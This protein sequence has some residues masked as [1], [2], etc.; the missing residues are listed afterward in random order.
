MYKQKS[1][2]GNKKKGKSR[3][4][5][6]PMPGFGLPMCTMKYAQALANPFSPHAYGACIP[7]GNFRP[8][9]K[10]HCRHFTSV[11]I[12]SGGF[13]YFMYSPCLANNSTCLF[14]TSSA[15]TGTAST[16]GN[17]SSVGV[18][19]GTMSTLP[20][21][22]TQLIESDSGGVRSEVQGRIVS[23]GIKWRYTG[24]E[25]NRG[26]TI[27]AYSDPLHETVEG[28][29]Y[30]QL[31][32]FAEAAMTAP[33]ANHQADYLTVFGCNFRELNYP[34]TTIDSSVTA[35][36]LSCIY[37]YSD[38]NRTVT[39][40]NTGAPIAVV[41]FQG[42]PLNTYQ[43]EVIMHSE[44][45]GTLA[46][47]MLTPNNSDEQGSYRV[48]AAASRATSA[49]ATG[50]GGFG[51]RFWQGYQDL[52]RESKPVLMDLYRAAKPM[53]RAYGD[54]QQSRRGMGSMIL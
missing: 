53:L 19:N 29:S 23:A 24:T 31:S 30:N 4:R 40:S 25:L 51:S 46:Q 10:N 17:T 11:T 22:R 15:Y 21:G 35:D 9:M 7:V 38:Q 1:K 49:G 16:P 48:Q 42:E 52:V 14:T 5:A 41:W 8:S 18:V 54:Y 32:G 50:N 43:I 12:G 36:T 37:P 3:P 45:E 34:D 26:G 47:Q 2:G 6:I 20:F 39:D 33:N 13:G 28:S 44:Y 27:L